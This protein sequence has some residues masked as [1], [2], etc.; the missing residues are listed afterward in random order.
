MDA[1]KT[2]SAT[3]TKRISIPGVQLP[4]AMALSMQKMREML[5]EF[6][7]LA[8]NPNAPTEEVDSIAQRLVQAGYKHELAE[9]LGPAL[10]SETPHPHL[11]V[12]WIQRLVTSHSW[13]RSYPDYLDELCER[14]EIGRRAVIALLEYLNQ[15]GKAAV[16]RKL[17][18]R[19]GRLFKA[20]P[21]GR[22]LIA[23]ALVKA[24]LFK[25]VLRW[26]N[27]PLESLD[28]R[29]LHARALA[30]REL[31]KERQARPVVKHA[32]EVRDA[33]TVYPVLG[34]WNA[35]EDAFQGENQAASLM[36]NKVRTAGWDEDGLTLYYLARGV[37]RV[38][39]APRE[40]RREAF[41]TAFDR[42]H[43]RLRHRRKICRRP[44]SLRR[45]YRRC[46][47]RMAWK[48]GLWGR[49]LQA[50]WESSDSW[51]VFLVL[52]VIPPFQLMAPFYLAR[53]LR[54]RNGSGSSHKG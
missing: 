35:M 19:H 45:A 43:D 44:W 50:V 4:N 6:S 17:V 26:T 8:T 42:V 20:D 22:S 23:G 41:Y 37:V 25:R 12:L 36:L 51:W 1:P 21:A 18:S 48:A 3:Q 9:V 33:L 49:G 46:V 47:W 13:S 39:Q 32:C 10:Q 15:K 7:K 2:A 30:L 11:G 52:L 5:A 28:A 54:N 38:Q 14:G 34:V 31:G 29:S 16:T 40:D 53:L 27:G 24:R